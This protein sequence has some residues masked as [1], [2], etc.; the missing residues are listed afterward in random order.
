MIYLYTY[1]LEVIIHF[2]NAPA[3][4]YSRLLGALSSETPRAIEPVTYNLNLHQRSPGR[5]SACS[6]RECMSDSYS[7]GQT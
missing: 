2:V 6:F 5:W 3:W 4:V 7:L 1:I